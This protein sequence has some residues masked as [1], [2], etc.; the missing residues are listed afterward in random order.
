[1]AAV[2]VVDLPQIEDVQR[3][4]DGF[5]LP[6]ELVTRIRKRGKQ[7]KTTGTTTRPRKT[8]KFVTAKQQHY[9]ALQADTNCL[10][11]D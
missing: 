1:M 8:N 5:I 11:V 2:N 3:D 4:T 6:P 7:N 10:C 9:G